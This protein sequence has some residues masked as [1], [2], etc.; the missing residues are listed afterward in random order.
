[1]TA[2]QGTRK[3]AGGRASGQWGRAREVG[4]GRLAGQVWC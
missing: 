3:Q 1:M 2:M 4:Q